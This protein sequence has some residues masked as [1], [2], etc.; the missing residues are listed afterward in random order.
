[1]ATTL[2]LVASLIPIGV[3]SGAVVSGSGTGSAVPSKPTAV[4]TEATSKGILVRIDNL[5][6]DVAGVDIYRSE[7]AGEEGVKLNDE[8]VTSHSFMDETAQV[9][10]Q[11]FYTVKVTSRVTAGK[12][13]AAGRSETADALEQVKAEVVNAG[14]H[15]KPEASPD[16]PAKK[17]GE[18]TDPSSAGT[19]ASAGQVSALAV[20]VAASGVTTLTRNTIWSPA[21]G[22]YYIRNDVVVPK[23]ITLTIE[24]GT[25]VYFDTAASGW[26]SSGTPANPTSGIDLIVHGKLVANGSS[27]D[28][29]L[30]TSIR[31][32]TASATADG[33][34]QQSDWGC[35]YTD[36]RAAS[37]I[38]RADVQYGTYGVWAYRTARPYVSASAFRDNS[39]SIYFDDPVTD[40]V[41]PKPYIKGNSITGTSDGILIY[42][43]IDAGNRGGK[44]LAPHISNNNI[45]ASTPI[46]VEIWESGTPASRGDNVIGGEIRNNIIFNES[47][48][49]VYIYTES[50]DANDCAVVTQFSGNE[51]KTNDNDV[52]DCEAYAYDSGTAWVRPSFYRDKLTGYNQAFYGEA[53]NAGSTVLTNTGG[54]YVNPLFVDCQLVSTDD[55]AIE[56]DA[57][58]GGSGAA[59]TTF[60]LLGGSAQSGSDYGAYCDSESQLGVAACSPAIDNALLAAH[61]GSDALYIDVTSYGAADVRSNPSITNS[62]LRA[63]DDYGIEI[64]A[65]SDQGAAI[66]KPSLVDS[67]VKSYY[68]GLYIDADSTTDATGTGDAF[69]SPVITNSVIESAEDDGIY[70]TSYSDGIGSTHMNPVITNSTIIGG[71]SY[72]IY[73]DPNTAG[74]LTEC[75]PV[76]KDSVVKGYYEALYLDVDRW[77]SSESY[78]SVAAPVVTNSL[79]QSTS[80]DGVF[81]GTWNSSPGGSLVKGTFT[82]TQVLA[83]Y[84]GG[85]DLYAWRTSTTGTAEVAPTMVRTD[86]QSG[87]EALYCYSVTSGAPAYAKAGGT[88]IDCTF[89][90]TWDNGVYVESNNAGKGVAVRPNFFGCDVKALQ[91]YGYEFYANAWGDASS[92]VLAQPLITGGSVESGDGIYAEAGS[93]SGSGNEDVVCDAT[94]QN[95]NVYSAWDYGVYTYAHAGGTGDAVNDSFI[96]NTNVRSYDGIENDADCYDWWGNVNGDGNATNRSVTAGVSTSD[97]MSVASYDSDGVYNW[98]RSQRGDVEDRSQV[99][100]LVVSAADSGLEFYSEA[101]LGNSTIVPVVSGNRF[102]SNWLMDNYGVYVY[103]SSTDATFS[104][105]LSGNDISQ[106]YG[107]GVYLEVDAGDVA[108]VKPTIRGNTIGNTSANN[109]EIDASGASTVDTASAISVTKNTLSKAGWC[110]LFVNSVPY[111]T[112]AQNKMSYPGWDYGWNGQFDTSCIFWR[113]VDSSAVVR[114]N[115]FKGA[116]SAAVFYEGGEAAKTN[117]NSF[118]DCNGVVNRPFNYWTDASTT[119]TP[120]FDARYNWWGTSSSAA[121]THQFNHPNYNGST[122]SLINYK[123]A[124]QSCAPTVKSLVITSS[125]GTRTFK[126][127]FDRVMDTSVKKLYFGSSSPFRTYSMTGTWDSSGKVFTG[128]FTGP[129]PTGVK[130]YLNGA[131]DLPGT[132]MTKWSFML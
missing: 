20:Q 59:S 96:Y 107:D 16:A 100:N 14:G 126:A 76:I 30:F 55:D 67:T 47:S 101:Q 50:Y 1:M 29:I 36:S 19:G 23:G 39:T 63:A 69:V 2:V 7:V 84:D 28:R 58:A 74:R 32:Y 77:G 103:S 4:E 48:E 123:G 79:L 53:D 27:A 31:S 41:T 110:N 54:A 65:S 70:L 80:D 119:T 34:P 75:R 24:P 122:A 115:M 88:F 114:G 132:P 68:D 10:V 81:M 40:A 120:I 98:T 15:A 117:W 116:R 26:G 121:Y 56:L 97:R 105:T 52:V 5:Q 72:G 108:L 17:G 125:G 64:Y 91:D 127:T 102:T 57:E 73:F 18:L 6:R 44:T 131:K 9:G 92:T 61:N 89:D 90:S 21:K 113:D 8:P 109:I 129:L 83:P 62:E 130:L 45:R 22:S 51:L 104:P 3:A 35:I 94:V 71:D 124:L 66:V 82:D 106:T 11:Y 46:D 87:D 13:S 99:R 93:T 49:P 37:T 43:S 85:F 112:V 12:V 78:D 25:R 86:V 38:S 111:G 118:G 128:K 33:L 60:G 95:V 42:W